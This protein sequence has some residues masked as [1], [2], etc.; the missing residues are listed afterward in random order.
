[1]SKKSVT[2]EA[3]ESTTAGEVRAIPLDI[4]HSAPWNKER[5]VDEAFVQSFRDHGQMV[6]SMARP[7]PSI[8]GAFEIVYGHR[9]AEGLRQ[10]GQFATMRCEVRDLS[11]QEA[12]ELGALENAQ[13]RGLSWQQTCNL[14]E[15]YLGRHMDEDAPARLAGALGLS[16]AQVKRRARLLAGLSPSWLDAIKGDQLPGWTVDHYEILAIFDEKRQEQ[17]HKD[18]RYRAAELTVKD[19]KEEISD[20]SKTLKSAPWDLDD[21]TLYGKAGACNGCPKRDDAQ[22]DLLGEVTQTKKGGASCLDEACFAKKLAA[23]TKRKE[24]DLLEKQPGAVKVG[25]SWGKAPKDALRPHE[26]TDA[27]KGDKGAVPALKYG[28]GGKVT[29]GYV[30]VK[31]SAKDPSEKDEA[32]QAEE[33]RLKRIE[34]LAIENL[35]ALVDDPDAEFTDDAAPLL[36]QY[37]LVKGCGL[38]LE[39]EEEIKRVRAF[40]KKPVTLEE[41]W[42]I[43]STDMRK[44][45]NCAKNS[46]DYNCDRKDIEAAVELVAWMIDADLKVL[47]KQAAAEVD[48]KPTAEGGTTPVEEFHEDLEDGHDAGDEEDEE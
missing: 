36:L 46:L 13:R 6:T 20:T 29:L 48:A 1:M 23:F 41:L 44:T 11:N 28:E 15:D 21:V 5:P 42:I 32:K 26:V 22:V 45:L 25:P 14:I 7:H 27:K 4:L 8:P 35:I 40:A 24:A 34:A 19:L 39:D 2:I 31:K 10:A 16:T 9:R 30:K 43:A 38:Q 17:L 18:L 37:C 33:R 12:E 47:R 3:P